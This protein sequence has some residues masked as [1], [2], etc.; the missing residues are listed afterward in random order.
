MTAIAAA[1]LLLTTVASSHAASTSGIG[2]LPTVAATR[3]ASASG[4]AKESEGSCWDDGRTDTSNA[5]RGVAIAGAVVPGVIVHGTGHWLADKP[6]TAR[7]IAAAEAVGLGGVIVG[8]STIVLTGA[9]RYLMLPAISLTVAGTALFFTSFAADVY[10][11]T[12][13]ARYAGDP[14]LVRPRWETEVGVL[15]VNNP[16]FEFEWLFSQAVAANVGAA[17]FAGTM[18]TALDETHARYRLGVTWRF[19]GPRPPPIE[20]PVPLAGADGT[21]MA[22]HSA[23]ITA[24]TRDGSFVDLYAGLMRQNYLDSRFVTD[25][26]ELLAT[27]RLDLVR[28]G[29]TLRGAFA[30]LSTG[31]AL[32]NTRYR[33]DGLRVPADDE[34]VLLGRLG[35]GMYLGRGTHR[36]SEVILYYDHRHDDYAAGLKIPGLGSGNLGHFG[37]AG[38][39]YWSRHWG[40]G[41]VAEVGSAYVTGL[42]VLF[43][44][45]G[46]R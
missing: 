34:S 4:D 12:G 28:L 17:R 27:G 25:S 5:R 16:S 23:D 44:S 18:D 2:E 32:S 37:I 38:Q 24:S 15:R 7:R 43:R 33:L 30:E 40:L 36:G 19:V 41:A 11:V 1:V 39:Y 29:P 21:H 46:A 42:R 9:S 8:G 31:V 13:A 14:L 20:S 6:C 35:F 10:G 26:A 22:R 45:G 3:Q